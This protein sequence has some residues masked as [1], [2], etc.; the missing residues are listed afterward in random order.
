MTTKSGQWTFNWH[1]SDIWQTGSYHNTKEDAIATAQTE[2][3]KWNEGDSFQ[4]G[5]VQSCENDIRVDAGT[6][7]E[8]IAENIYDEVGEVADDYL[9][10]VKKEDEEIL[11]KRLNKV[12]K[13]WMIEFMYMPDFYKVTNI[14]LI[15]VNNN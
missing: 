4:I 7:L 13:D 12:I 6:I 10:H 14:E 8:Q 2:E 15:K 1:N 11:D 3:F 5:Q 9:R